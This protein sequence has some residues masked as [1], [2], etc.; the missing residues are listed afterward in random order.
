[1]SRSRSAPASSASCPP[2]G[3]GRVA[4]VEVAW[5]D[6]FGDDAVTA[7]RGALEEISGRLADGLTPYPVG[8]RRK[9]TAL[10]VLPD[11]P[12]VL[13]RGGYPDGV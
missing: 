2:K 10:S 4:E 13:H 11:Y 1:M 6:R 9:Q 8:W 5:R 7:L 3:S 12:M